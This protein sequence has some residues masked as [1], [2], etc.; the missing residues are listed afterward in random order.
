MYADP[1]PGS[2]VLSYDFL[3]A[4]LR[5]GAGLRNLADGGPIQDGFYSL[6]YSGEPE[7]VL[8][9]IY[10]PPGC[11]RVLDPQIDANFPQLSGEV[12]DLIHFSNPDLIS[13]T[14]DLIGERFPYWS[15]EPR[16]TWC[17]YFEKADLA[18]QVGDWEQVG[19]LGDVAYAL[20]DDANHPAEHTPFIEGYAMVGDWERALDLTEQA[21][22]DNSLMQPMLCDLWM[23]IGGVNPSA[24]EGADGILGCTE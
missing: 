21:A 24:L 17:Y 6:N 11:L 20:E 22:A 7:N 9:L 10:D 18:R 5:A 2:T 3:Y 23:R 4:D 8:I 14:P 1:Q 13:P 12:D 19:A 16:E 15:V